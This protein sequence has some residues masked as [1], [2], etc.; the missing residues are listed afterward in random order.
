MFKI[1]QQT[2]SKTVK[3]EGVG[4]HTGNI[5]KVT[6]K[7][8]ENNQGI[9]FKRIDLRKNNIVRANFKNVSTAKLC[10][11]LENDHGTKVST[12]EHLLAAFYIYGID[13]ALVEVDN[14]EIP[15]MDGSAKDF[16]KI[17]NKIELKELSEKRKFLQV[18]EKIQLVDGQR[19]ISIEPSSTDFEVEFQLNY[20]NKLISNQ[21]NLIN[22]QKDDLSDVVESRTFCL[23]EDIEKI[24]KAGLAKGGS[25][26]NA[27]VVDKNKVLNK[28][29]LRNKKEFVNHKILDLAGDF[30]LAGYRCLG[31]ID[32]Y[33]GGHQLTNLFLRKLMNTKSFDL[34][35]LDRIVVSNKIS[36]NSALKIAVNA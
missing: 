2:L 15:I 31:K 16:L 27:V 18:S 10:T 13:N 7:P 28:D 23:Y 5:S 4:L 11:T 12:V 30:V 9:I 6:V 1:F 3:F 19:K 17:L 29:G 8:A 20:K 24:K 35:E 34:I 32:C 21:K 25:L 26:S 22:F 33:Q 14:E 36:R